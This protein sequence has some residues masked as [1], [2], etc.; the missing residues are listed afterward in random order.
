MRHL[1]IFL[2]SLISL[3]LQG[4]ENFNLELISHVE[5]PGGEDGNDIWGYV[6]SDSTEYAIVGSRSNTHIYN[7]SDPTQ[8]RLIISIP[9]DATT[10]RDMKSWED[11][12]YVTA[13][14]AGD[15]LLVIDMSEV[16]TDSI[17]F[18]F[19]NP[20]VT[21]VNGPQRL[22]SCHNIFIDENGYAYLAGCSDG[23][24]K[25]II[26]DLNVDKW[27]PTI[28]GVHGVTNDEY[29][30]DLMVKNN[31]M[32]SSE[33]NVG[34]LALYDVTDKAN[35]VELGATQ[36][37]F[38]FTHNAWSSDDQNFVF[39]TDERGNAF[40]DS[41]DVSDPTNIRRLDMFQPAETAGNGVIPHNT[42]YINGFL[43]TSW[44]TDGVV[45]TDASRPDNMVKVGSYDT[46]LGPDGGFEG[47]WGVYP[48]LPSGLV[49]AN[50]INSGLYVFKPNYVRACH[51]EGNVVSSEDGT[52]INGVT[53][54]ILST[55]NNSITNAAGD[56]KGGLLE[57]GTYTLRYSHPLYLE[58]EIENVV[59]EN[60]ELTIQDAELTPLTR[61]LI[62][63]T[64]VDNITGEPIPSGQLVFSTPIKTINGSAN[65]QG[66]FAIDAFEEDYEVVVAAWGYLHKVV[67]SFNP[68][69]DEAIFRLDPGYMDDFIL[70]LG[71]MEESTSPRGVWERAVPEGTT[72]DG[73]ISNI[74][75]DFI[76]D[77]GDLAY[78]TGND[79]RGNAGRDDVDSGFTTLSSPMMLL[80]DYVE[81][82]IE[83]STHFYNG[84][85]AA[86]DPL[87]DNF[88]ITLNDGTQSVMIV[89]TMDNSGGWTAVTSY[90][91]SDYG[92]DTDNPIW[93]EFTA[94]D[95]EPGHL[96]EAAIDVF[97]VIE[98]EP[99]KT[100]ETIAATGYF[101][102]Y[103]N[104][105]AD[106]ITISTELEG[107]SRVILYD[108]RGSKVL[109]NTYA[110]EIDLSNYDSGL[111][112]LEILMEQGSRYSARIIV[113]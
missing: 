13:D 49:I 75:E 98:G 71:W 102:I 46:Y 103:P 81:P 77:I 83:F 86:G 70:D 68:V 41:Y 47:C 113:E 45:I 110:N 43:V 25:A 36:T 72:F 66:S 107:M 93:I 33:I 91:L 104:P 65:A 108:Q 105:T 56:Y 76:G 18:Q 3:F 15:G 69:N 32:Y 80:Q 90:R 54:E 48:W 44:Y 63:G 21:T 85:G 62:E 100:E 73:D 112:I 87:N 74:N 95:N 27:N 59:L 61:A 53:V 14:A 19:L 29:A 38:D 109:D 40:V 82:T 58:L 97:K 67:G 22:A 37:S 6:H 78:V 106:R 51:L 17:R 42:H 11:H 92:M 94:T 79:G 8:P 34:R 39:T 111:Y 99:S 89:N 26:F 9:G 55:S 96:V 101:S 88:T 28:V 50:D 52:A 60:G 2:F 10:W 23:M 30:H 16:H 7:L 20:D 1:L 4:Q 31:I 5:H 84:G 64:I 35:I 24:N 12:V 57:A